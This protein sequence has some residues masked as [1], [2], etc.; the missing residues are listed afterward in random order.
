MIRKKDIPKLETKPEIIICGRHVNLGGKLR[1]CTIFIYTEF[2]S[3]KNKKPCFVVEQDGK[4][5]EFDIR[6]NMYLDVEDLK[7]S[8]RNET[9]L[10]KWLRKKSNIYKNSSNWDTISRLWQKY[11]SSSKYYYLKCNLDGKYTYWDN[12]I[13]HYYIPVNHQEATKGYIK[14]K[15]DEP[16]LGYSFIIYTEYSNHAWEEPYFSIINDNGFECCIDLRDN[17]Y[18]SFSKDKLSEDQCIILNNYMNIVN[19]GFYG[20]YTNWHQ[21]ICSWNESNRFSRFKLDNIIQPNYST[22]KET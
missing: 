10:C 20:D 7:F 4:R 22:I 16:F 5:T 17:K 15:K 2:G 1:N 9:E 6:E 3:N 13:R 18:M 8:K 14:N 19:H 21:Y 11:N 12:Y